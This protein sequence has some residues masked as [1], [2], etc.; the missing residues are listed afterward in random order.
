MRPLTDTQG[1]AYASTAVWEESD[2]KETIR[3]ILDLA[4][5]KGASDVHIEPRPDMISVK[6]RIDGVLRQVGQLQD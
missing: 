4:A 6:Y 3:Y 1:A 5:R 2:P